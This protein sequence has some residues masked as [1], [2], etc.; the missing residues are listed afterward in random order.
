M[1][2]LDSLRAFCVALVLCE[3]WISEGYWFKIIPFGMIGVTFFFVL[4]GFLITEILIKGKIAIEQK[5]R[6]ALT[7]FKN[8]YARRTLRIFPVYYLTI[9]ILYAM[10]FEQIRG[11]VTWFLFY[12]SNIY[13]YLNQSWDGAL[14]HLWTLAVEEQ[15]YLIWPLIILLVS[16]K[17]LLGTII[18]F[19]ITGIL[20][21]GI[22]FTMSDNSPGA[23]NFISILTPSCID[24]FALGG[25][26]AYYRIFGNSNFKFETIT[27]R[28]FLLIN[29]ALM[30]FFL[31]QEENLFSASL[32]R[33]NVSV[34][35]LYII[36][37]MSLGYKGILKKIFEN[38]FL[39]YLGK[40]SYGMYLFHK[41][42]PVIYARS[43]FAEISNLPIRLS[44]YLAMLIIL[45]SLSWYLLEKPVNSLKKYFAYN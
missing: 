8:F 7:V 40:I 16:R 30:I 6:N 35:A 36:S 11:K 9:I 25:I 33:F 41:F 38:K 28:F 1:P 34:V 43:G 18:I 42:I 29:I 19:L 22:L 23:F 4:S 31:F 10:N 14:S 3:H 15:F 12:L 17:K 24:S 44:V 21:R 2:Q 26:L 39:M 27:F 45:S 20:F 13:F 5:S 37:G 32:Y